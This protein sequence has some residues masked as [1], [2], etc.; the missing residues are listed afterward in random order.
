MIFFSSFFF[1][2]SSAI[3][4]QFISSMSRYLEKVFGQ[5]GV[6]QDEKDN[7]VVSHSRLSETRCK[8]KKG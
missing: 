4:F 1:R 8:S 5:K 7:K 3:Y 2:L 6:Q